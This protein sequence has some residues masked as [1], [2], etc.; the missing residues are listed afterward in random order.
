M[1]IKDDTKQEALFEATI[2]VVNEIGFAS[3]SVSKIAKEAGISP[4]TIYIYH[5]NKED[6]L[7]S[8]YM[9]VKK[10]FTMTLLEGFDDG[11]PI[12][13]IFKRVWYNGFKYASSY[14]AHF[15]FKEQFANSPYMELVD[16]SEIDAMLMLIITI[17]K[18]GIEEK[19]LKDVDMN[20]FAAFMY[21]PI[22]ALSNLQTG[23][24]F[25]VNDEIIDKA[26]DMAWEAIK[27]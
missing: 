6:L 16:E 1:R 24:E 12:R 11:L 4:A 5:E 14:K 9:K 21:Y 23:I 19:I 10:N 8:T 26:F 25:E 3:S 22:V 2:K 18:R 7:V 13:D 17:F 20:L 15:R 27:L